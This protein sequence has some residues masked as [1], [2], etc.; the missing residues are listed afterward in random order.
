MKPVFVAVE[1]EPNEMECWL[2]EA[3]ED[4]SASC[5]MGSDC[6]AIGSEMNSWHK[7]LQFVCPLFSSVSPSSKN[8]PE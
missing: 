4:D 5:L 6:G 2:S 8:P 3:S 7:L 1:L